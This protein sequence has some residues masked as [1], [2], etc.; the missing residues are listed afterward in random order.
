MVSFVVFVLLSLAVLQPMAMAYADFN[1]DECSN[2]THVLIS[3][4]CR[5][6]GRLCIDPEY[7]RDGES[8]GNTIYR[9]ALKCC[10]VGCFSTVINSYCCQQIRRTYSFDSHTH[11]NDET[12]SDEY[13]ER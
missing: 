2:V 13:E 4:T 7:I 10:S 5:L 12:A 1:Y 9:L 11:Y 6:A 8:A 3:K